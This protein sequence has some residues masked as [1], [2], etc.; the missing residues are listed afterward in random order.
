MFRIGPFPLGLLALIL[1]FVSAPARAGDPAG[2]TQYEWS[3]H[4][5]LS[6]GAGGAVGPIGGS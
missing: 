5:Y 2:G 1:A 4:Q 6:D 3:F